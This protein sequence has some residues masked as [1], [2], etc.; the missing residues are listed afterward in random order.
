MFRVLKNPN[1]ARKHRI[2]AMI[3]I[4]GFCYFVVMNSIVNYVGLFSVLPSL[5]GDGPSMPLV[6]HRLLSIFLVLNTLGNFFLAMGTNSSL[7]AVLA[8]LPTSIT[9]ELEEHLGRQKVKIRCRR[10]VTLVPPGSH[11]CALCDVCVLRR[12]HHCFFMCTCIGHRN[13][14]HFI[15]F[16]FWQTAAGI[17]AIFQCSVH[18]N[19]VYGMQLSSLYNWISCFHVAMARW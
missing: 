16:C 7:E 3:N 2:M 11:H 10:C 6:C 18:L 17:Y 12:D 1:A 5:Y 8:T 19:Q 14:K 9:A 4:F 15:L 13:Q